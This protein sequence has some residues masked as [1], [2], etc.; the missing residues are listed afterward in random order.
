VFTAVVSVVIV[1]SEMVH[2]WNHPVLSLV[3]IIIRATGQ[4]WFFL[5]VRSA[6]F[7]VN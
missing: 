3:G 4:N 2:N 5:E 7:M 6:S 1:W